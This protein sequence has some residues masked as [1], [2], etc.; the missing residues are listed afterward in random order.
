MGSNLLALGA[1]LKRLRVEVHH[2]RECFL[3][4]HPALEWDALARLTSLTSLEVRWEA[5][6]WECWESVCAG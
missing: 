3:V 1:S 5:G 4:M 6:A 2:R